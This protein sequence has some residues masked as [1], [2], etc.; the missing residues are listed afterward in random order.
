MG[1]R[2]PGAVS[3]AV[4]RKGNAEGRFWKPRR[5]TK[6]L[7]GT[8]KVVF[9]NTFENNKLKNSVWTTCLFETLVKDVSG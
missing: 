4:L 1:R 5:K 9:N 2:A 3:T 7:G 8:I 6:D